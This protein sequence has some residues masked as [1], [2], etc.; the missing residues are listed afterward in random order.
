M[1]GADLDKGE[2]E[3]RRMEGMICSMTMKERRHPQVLN[4]KRRIRISKGAGV[5]VAELNS[6]LK[7]FGQMQKMMKKMGKMSKMM[8]KLGGGG[9]DGLMGGGK[10]GFR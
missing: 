10:G 7:R 1:K 3:F 2:K 8:G 5:S 4:A 9:L 6:M